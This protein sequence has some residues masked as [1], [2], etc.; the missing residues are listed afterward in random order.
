MNSETA[1]NHTRSNNTSR[2]FFDLLYRYCL[3]LEC[4][5]L[6][7]TVSVRAMR[8]IK[9]HLTEN[10]DISLSLT[11]CLK[12]SGERRSQQGNNI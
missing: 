11:F 3:I 7:F 9:L 1:K 12:Y 4:M 5:K 6:I 8:A 10:F 2:S